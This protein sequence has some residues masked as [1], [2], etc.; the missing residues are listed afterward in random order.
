MKPGLGLA[1]TVFFGSGAFA[2]P[3]LRAIAE[4]EGVATVALVVSAPP[5]PSG[6][7][8]QP[9]PNPVA[10]EAA[11]LGLPLAEAESPADAIAE[12]K[13]AGARSFVVCDYGKLLPRGLLRLPRDGG[14]NIHPSLLPRWRG[15]SPIRSAILAGD[16][17]TGVTIMKMDTGLDTGGI[18]LVRETAIGADETAGALSARLAEAGAELILEALANL[19]DLAERPQSGEATYAARLGADARWLDFRNSAETESRRIRAFA[20]KPGARMI[21]R[22]VNLKALAGK[23]LPDEKI[24]AGGK[25]GMGLEGSDG[26]GGGKGLEGWEGKV[27]SADRSGLTIGCGVGA[28]V[29]TRL[30]REGGKELAAGEFLLGFPAAV[31]DSVGGAEQR[32]AG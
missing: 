23:V 20:P 19:R 31:G 13:T 1:R 6:R 8:L 7:K 28:L 15:A 16:Q 27:L 26:G 18:L 22:G 11:R 17:K 3:S 12:I 4:S 5:R 32:R 25:G 2:A 29:L 14:L 30:Q 21:L 10:A 24:S 9:R